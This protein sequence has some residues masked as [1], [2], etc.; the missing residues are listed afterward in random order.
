MADYS[1]RR[2]RVASD[3]FEKRKNRPGVRITGYAG[4]GTLGS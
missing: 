2:L 3:R 4:K 1:Q